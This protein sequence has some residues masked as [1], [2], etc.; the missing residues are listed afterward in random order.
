MTSTRPPLDPFQKLALAT[1]A[2]TYLLIL[3]G[4]LVRAAGAGLGCPD[5]PRCFGSWI[6]PLNASQ[7][8]PEFDP[9]LF[10]PFH[11][12]LEYINRLLGVSIGLLI[13]A[14]LV[15][16]LRRHRAVA[17]ILWPTVLATLLVGY[18]GW[19]GG[20][21][22]KSGL[23]P[24]MVTAHLVVA[25][26][27][28]SLLLYATV[29]AFFPAGRALPVL[30]VQRQT[31]ARWGLALL[32]LSLTQVAVGTQVRSGI[33]LVVRE[34]PGLVRGEWLAQVG[35]MDMAHRELSLVVL[36]ASAVLLW[37]LRRWERAEGPLI[38]AAWW[39]L[40]LAALQIALGVVLA[41][42][43]LPS[44]AQV[45]H[46]TVASLLLGANTLLILLASRLPVAESVEG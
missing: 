36:L 40:G 30:P 4:G 26:V 39:V 19:L 44:A 3:V 8:P 5:W 16:A 10:N 22:V 41:Y 6:P 12:W 24:W 42:L 32:L 31:L 29:N 37:W 38:R 27:I 15:A 14:T 34:Q 17:G 20:Q 18:Q 35:L 43:N 1:T 21:V 25:L 28:V 46:L 9:S 23:Q 2:S 45:G 13:V 7:L 33:E 11:T